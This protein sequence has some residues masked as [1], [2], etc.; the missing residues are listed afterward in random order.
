MISGPSCPVEGEPDDPAS[1]PPPGIA[2]ELTAIG[3][4]KIS[5]GATCGLDL[6]IVVGGGSIAAGDEA[7]VPASEESA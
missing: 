4:M 1:V 6:R 7:D 5:P 2:R 3:A